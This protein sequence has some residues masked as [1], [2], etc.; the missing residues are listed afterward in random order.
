[1]AHRQRHTARVD[2]SIGRLCIER[3]F[4]G[5]A[6][7]SNLQLF[8]TAEASGGIDFD[9]WFSS[10]TPAIEN[11]SRSEWNRCQKRPP[12]QWFSWL[13]ELRRIVHS[14]G[15]YALVKSRRP[16]GLLRWSGLWVVWKFLRCVRRWQKCGF[17]KSY[18][19]MLDR[20]VHN[21]GRTAFAT[22]YHSCPSWWLSILCDN[23]VTK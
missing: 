9:F 16:R 8:P 15:I 6:A 7:I 23:S 19:E 3:V 14:I 17:R 5:W 10:F 2:G 1:M 4:T 13:W 18:Q 11:I 22:E 12:W 21:H 20:Q